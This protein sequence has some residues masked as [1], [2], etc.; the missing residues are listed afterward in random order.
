MIGIEARRET[1]MNVPVRLAIAAITFSAVSIAAQPSWATDTRTAIKL[2]DNN[3]NC[4][5][6]VSETSVLLWVKDGN[7]GTTYVDCPAPGQSGECVAVR[8]QGR[9]VRGLP[10]AGGPLN[11][12]LARE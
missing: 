1:P 9:Q 5:Y 8:K 4:D 3:P 11:G 7:G 6:R 12:I 2:C 10:G